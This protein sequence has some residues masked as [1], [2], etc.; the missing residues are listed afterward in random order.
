MNCAK[1]FAK[2]MAFFAASKSGSGASSSAWR[3]SFASSRTS[4]AQAAISSVIRASVF[5]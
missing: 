4:W 1:A 3:L 5:A 2:S